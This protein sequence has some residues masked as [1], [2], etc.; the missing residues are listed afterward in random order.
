MFGLFIK[1]EQIKGLFDA[2]ADRL[3]SFLSEH[4][5]ELGEKS[6]QTNRQERRN[7]AAIESLYAGQ[8]EIL[9]ILRRM[10]TESPKAEALIGFA[11]NFAIWRSSAPDTPEIRVLWGKLVALLEQFGLEFLGSAGEPFDPAIHEACA[12]RFDPEAPLNSILEIIRP[13]FTLNGEAFRYAI[14][15][16]NRANPEKNGGDE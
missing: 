9:A 13:G 2:L 14:V 6:S 15:V 7:Q 10:A 3:E 4:F 8:N 11:E 16:I 12:V 5:L 1:L